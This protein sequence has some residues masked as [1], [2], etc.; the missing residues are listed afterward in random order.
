MRV[1]AFP[2]QSCTLAFNQRA[3][4]RYPIPSSWSFWIQVMQFLEVGIWCG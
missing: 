3:I 1:E 4:F 2:E